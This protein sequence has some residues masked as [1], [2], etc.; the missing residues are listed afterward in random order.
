MTMG[1]PARSELRTHHQ[2]LSMRAEAA[3]SSVTAGVRGIP[4][5]PLS[6]AT[7]DEPD[8]SDCPS[9]RARPGQISAART[10]SLGSGYRATGRGVRHTARDCRR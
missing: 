8:E 4:A 6:I 3:L 5:P 1:E 2:R 10:G 7:A 9:P